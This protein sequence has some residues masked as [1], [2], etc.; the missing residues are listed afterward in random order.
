M[1]HSHENRMESREMTPQELSAY[2]EAM[3]SNTIRTI[4]KEKN[5]KTRNKMFRKLALWGTLTMLAI[6]AP[7]VKAQDKTAISDSTKIERIADQR[8]RL[9]KALKH[10]EYPVD[11]A[12]L[13]VFYRAMTT[14]QAVAR[15][16]LRQE[17]MEPAGGFLKK[18]F[19]DAPE[20]LKNFKGGLEKLGLPEGTVDSLAKIFA[21]KDVI[22]LNN[23]LFKNEQKF[24]E[25]LLHERIHEAMNDLRTED[26][27]SLKAGYEDVINHASIP[28]NPD[29]N[30][31]LSE[32]SFLQDKMDTA[33]VGSYG[34][35]TVL[36]TMNWDEF[37]PYLANGK[38]V[39]R[40]EEEVEKAHPSAYR[41]FKK[42]EEGAKVEIPK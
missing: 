2:A 29:S 33:N 15:E 19:L 21:S 3:E 5:E 30:F 11:P 6:A 38:F 35:Y 24:K 41:I 42:M 22:V 39:P 26:L 7:E 8:E 31:G 13:E 14:N 27:D 40:V 18:N 32:E 16:E 34:W 37:Y 4:R 1:M 25:V 36:A 17:G 12:I 23:D 20:R 28:V 9:E 10:N